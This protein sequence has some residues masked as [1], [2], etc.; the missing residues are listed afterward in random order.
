MPFYFSLPQAISRF[1]GKESQ[2]TNKGQPITLTTPKPHH[3]FTVSSTESSCSVEIN[4]FSMFSLNGMCR[5]GRILRNIFVKKHSTGLSGSKTTRDEPLFPN[6]SGAGTDPP[7]GYQQEE[8]RQYSRIDENS[9]TGSYSDL[10]A[11]QGSECP[12]ER[13]EPI[14]VFPSLPFENDGPRTPGV[15]QNLDQFD[16][17]YDIIVQS[18]MGSKL[19]RRLT[20]KFDADVNIMSDDMQHRLGTELRPYHGGP[21]SITGQSHMIPLGTVGVSW[22]FCGQTRIYK[23]D[24]YVV[25]D[26]TYDFLIGRPSIRSH[27]L[28]RVDPEITRRLNTSYQGQNDT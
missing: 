2:T 7:S 20:L 26:M 22:T 24:F 4:Q 27:E 17:V 9:A 23:T 1:W 3:D 28:Y 18:P 8:P 14:N 15:C 19:R 12:E 25:P 6:C 5:A 10:Q 16:F 13:G 21:I 11:L